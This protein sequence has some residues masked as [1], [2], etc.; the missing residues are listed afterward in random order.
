MGEVIGD[1][2]LISVAEDAPPGTYRLGIGMYNWAANM[3]S[4]PLYDA[5]GVRQ[6][7]DRLMLDVEIT[8]LDAQTADR[9]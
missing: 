5:Q 9:P 4:V 7:D 1:R 8:V 3:Q 2:Y 6:P